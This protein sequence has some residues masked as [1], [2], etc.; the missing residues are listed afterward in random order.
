MICSWAGKPK[1]DKILIN[2]YMVNIN[3][4]HL[5]HNVLAISFILK[6]F[7]FAASRSKLN[8]CVK[9]SVFELPH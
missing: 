6:K 9:R 2:F 1:I 4:Y 3:N 8:I 5:G 7:Y